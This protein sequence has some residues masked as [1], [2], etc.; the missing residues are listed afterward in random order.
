MISSAL[1]RTL[2]RRIIFTFK[3]IL[4]DFEKK[5]AFLVEVLNKS[6]D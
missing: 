2:L 1:I 3:A 6:K 5:I 4:S